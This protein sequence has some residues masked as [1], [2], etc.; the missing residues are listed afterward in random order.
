[1]LP[2]HLVCKYELNCEYCNTTLARNKAPW[3]WSDK[4]ETCR[5]VLKCFKVFYVKLFV[6]SLVDKL[7][8]RYWTLCVFTLTKSVFTRIT[9]SLICYLRHECRVY[10]SHAQNGTQHSLPSKLFYFFGS[11]GVSILWIFC[12]YIHA[13]IRT[14]VHTQISMRRD[15]IWITVPTK[16][17]WEWTIFTQIRSGANCWLDIYHWG[18][19]LA[20]AGWKCENEH[21][22][23]QTSFQ[24]GIGISLQLPPHFLPYHIPRRGLC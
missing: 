3:W 21:N 24:T 13:Y 19:G 14:Y 5:N 16:E 6:H 22:V 1:M 2:Q 12:V 17:Y 7:K 15:S 4:I 8:W 11:T 10:C 18:T 20:A 23:L 9:G